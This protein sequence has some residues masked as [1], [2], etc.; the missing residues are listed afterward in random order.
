[1]KMQMEGCTIPESAVVV[2]ERNE[3]LWTFKTSLDLVAQQ[4]NEVK[5][6]LLEVEYPL[7]EDQLLAADA[8]LEVIEKNSTWNTPGLVI[9]E[10]KNC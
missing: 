8:K 6:A 3:E 5:G 7:I 9:S 4:Y 10:R 1:M 2:F